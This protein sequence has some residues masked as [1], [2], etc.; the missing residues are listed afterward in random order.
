M[1]GFAAT[2]EAALLRGIV[3]DPTVGMGVAEGSVVALA[4][5]L[6]GLGASRPAAT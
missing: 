1:T 3:P 6:D 4:R 5:A 2:G